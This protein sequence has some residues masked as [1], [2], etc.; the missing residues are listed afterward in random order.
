VLLLQGTV[1]LVLGIAVGRWIPPV[2][3]IWTPSFCLL[4][5]GIATLAFT[6]VRRLV[7][8]RRVRAIV[9]TLVAFGLSPLLVWSGQSLVETLLSAKGAVSTDG[10]WRSLWLLSY[11]HVAAHFADARSA[12]L[13][14]AL[15]VTFCWWTVCGILRRRRLQSISRRLAAPPGIA[16]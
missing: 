10:Q 9:P 15:L 7:D 3:Y 8:V 1:L 2:M 11:D 16:P 12:T 14:F 5:A 4:T 13:A 6:L